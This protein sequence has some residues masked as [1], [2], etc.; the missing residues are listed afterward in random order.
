MLTYQ[1]DLLEVT[2]KHFGQKIEPMT[3]K[4]PKVMYFLSLGL[5]IMSFVPLIQRPIRDV[6]NANF[7]Q[8]FSSG[9]VCFLMLCLAVAVFTIGIKYEFADERKR[10]E[11]LKQRIRV[12]YSNWYLD[13]LI[14]FLE[15]KYNIKFN[16]ER[17]NVFAEEG[18][19]AKAENGSM[20]RVKLGGVTRE[21][22]QYDDGS[23]M[24][25][26]PDVQFTFGGEVWLSE[27]THDREINFDRMPPVAK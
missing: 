27:A 23:M 4:F 9:G 19:W 25:G 12:A 8:N 1:N 22:T 11:K 24:E 14:P 20:I 2:P 18:E 5:G 10:R 15:G 21:W 3:T 6:L 26:Y 7:E 16:E 17:S 13:T